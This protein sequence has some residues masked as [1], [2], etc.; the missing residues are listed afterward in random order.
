MSRTIRTWVLAVTALG[1]LQAGARAC[2][3]APRD[4]KGS[5]EET[6][7]E[8]I[9]FWQEGREDLVLKVD[10][11]LTPAQGEALPASLAWVIPVPA[12]PDR[13][14]EEDPDIFVDMFEAW[15][16]QT[17]PPLPVASESEQVPS[18]GD[19]EPV[20]IDLLP[21]ATVGAYEIQPIR[22]RGS[23]GAAALDAWLGG[24]GF[25]TVPPGDMAY[26]VE[27]DWVWLA[28]RIHPTEGEGTLAAE[29]GLRPLRIS[30]ASE[31]IVYPLKFSTGQ[32]VFDV[33][34]YLVTAEPIDFRGENSLAECR[35][36]AHAVPRFVLPSSVR[37]L[38]TK[39]ERQG[40]PDLPNRP[41]VT[42]LTGTRINGPDNRIDSWARDFGVRMISG[43][44]NGRSETRRAAREARRA[45]RHSALYCSAECEAE[46]RRAGVGPE[47]CSYCHK[48]FSVHVCARHA[49]EHG[50]CMGCG[51]ER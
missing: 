17:N 27:R 34:L 37:A 47:D 6:A 1:A 49:R 11:R 19:E 44:P 35:F 21:K 12:V 3:C 46:A 39:A 16:K 38:L 31:G 29:G 41:V 42:K 22:T 26:Y 14:E 45:T 20:G 43:S 18:F 23:E 4:Y 32:G 51:G 8:A 50:V 33:N 40:F 5:H 10:Y 48:I 7:Q 9:V 15:E 28:I 24:N 2:I 25:G 13:Y 30:F 36:V